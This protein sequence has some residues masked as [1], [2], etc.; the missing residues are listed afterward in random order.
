MVRRHRWRFQDK[1]SSGLSWLERRRGARGWARG[2]YGEGKV[3]VGE[4]LG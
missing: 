1:D 3:G 4:K 2:N